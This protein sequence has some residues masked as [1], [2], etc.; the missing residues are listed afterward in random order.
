MLPGLEVHTVSAKNLQFESH[1]IDYDLIFLSCS[2]YI[3]Q[4]PEYTVALINHLADVKVSH[5]DR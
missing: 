3:A 4:F 5:W 2:V 1:T